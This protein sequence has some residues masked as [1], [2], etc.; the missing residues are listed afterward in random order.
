MQSNLSVYECKSSPDEIA[1][2]EEINNLPENLEENKNEKPVDDR[3]GDEIK[4]DENKLYD[5]SNFSL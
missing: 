3:T 1:D 4:E 2:G 5:I